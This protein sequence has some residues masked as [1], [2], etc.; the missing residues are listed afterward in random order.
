M[1]DFNNKLL[2][3]NFY[4]LKIVKISFKS[5]VIWNSFS[6]TK[7]FATFEFLSEI[8]IETFYDWNIQNLLKKE[9]IKCL[10]WNWIELKGMIKIG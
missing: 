5:Y 6:I 3:I 1:N 4:H 10:N 9:C 8:I 7:F 2:R